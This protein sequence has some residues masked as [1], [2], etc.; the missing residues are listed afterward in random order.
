M[1]SAKKPNNEI[2]RNLALESY[3]VLDTS[4]EKV[5]DQLTLLAAQICG[6]NISL[7]SLID[8]DRQWFKSH[9]GLDATETPRELAFCAHSVYDKAPLF[10]SD[11]RKDERFFDNPL[12]TGAPNVIFYAG[13]PLIDQQGYALGTLCVIDSVPKELTP[14]QIDSLRIIAEQV[15]AQLTLRREQSERKKQIL[16]IEQLTA[17]APGVIYQ[18]QLFKDG[19]SCFP[20]A[21]EAINDIYEV[22]PAEVQRDSSIVFSRICNEE[23]EKVSASIQI[24]AKNLTN[25]SLDYKVKL[26]QKGVRWLRGFARPQL[27]SDESTL[28]H[29]F[30]TDVTIEKNLQLQLHQNS[31]MAALGEMA[32]GIAH[33]I[34]NPLTVIVGKAA[35]LRKDLEQKDFN[36]EKML[37]AISKI[38]STSHR[39]SKIIRGLKDFSRNADNDPHTEISVS[40]LFENVAELVQ[41]KFKFNQIEFKMKCEKKIKISC[42]ATQ[43]EQ[44][45]MNLVNNS[46]DSVKTLQEKWIHTSVEDVGSKVLITVTDSGKGI[47]PGIVEKIMNPF[48]TTKAVGEGTGLGLSLSKGLIESHHGKLYYDSSSANTKFVIELPKI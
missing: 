15:I 4:E 26:P 18:F 21:S 23:L 14:I 2:Q 46:F 19:R 10:V 7:I 44:V 20:F 28:W 13:M 1:K 9:T 36:P 32:S 22:T 37:S 11:A 34:N 42:N 30:I 17:Q 38:E 3:E 45:L 27:L 48:F 35:I 6:T 8:K 12:V 5:F 25:W 31:K 33:E 16:K 29:G 39:I 41:E 47:P 43:I 24:S 40:T